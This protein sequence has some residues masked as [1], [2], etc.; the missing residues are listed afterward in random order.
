MYYLYND[1]YRIINPIALRKAKIVYNFGL[2]ECNKVNI[3]G[4]AGEYFFYL[5]ETVKSKGRSY[6]LKPCF[7]Y[8]EMV[9][10]KNKTKKKNREVFLNS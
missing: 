4:C 10:K 9:K 1:R 2:S 8:L 6:I 7:P 3:I 5:Y